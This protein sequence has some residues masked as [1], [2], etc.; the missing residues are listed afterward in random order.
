MI[1]MGVNEFFLIGIVFI[2]PIA[3]LYDLLTDRSLIASRTV[4]AFVII[5][6]PMIGPIVY[7]LF[8]RLK[9]WFFNNA[10]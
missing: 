8:T 9:F 5:G 7:L 6:I 1:Q 4:W 2:L 10:R 3:A